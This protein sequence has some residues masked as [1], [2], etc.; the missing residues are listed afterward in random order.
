MNSKQRVALA[1]RGGR[2]DRVP[3]VP[4]FDAG[5]IC[6][7]TRRDPR[8]LSTCGAAERIRAIEEC[9][10]RH[11]QLDGLHVNS[12]CSEH[13]GR[14]LRIEK[15]STH[16]RITNT[17]T[18]EQWGLRPDA[19]ACQPDGTL[20]PPEEPRQPRIS[21]ADDVQRLIPAPPTPEQIEASGR[22]GPLRHLV[23]NYPDR[24]YSYPSHSLM[25]VAID[26]CGGFAAGLTLLATRR[27]LFEKLLRRWAEHECAVVES[28][29]KAGADSMW[30]ISYFA[31]AD[32]ISPRDYADLVFPCE[33]EICR[34]AK[35][36]G[37]FVL[38]WYLGDLMPNLEQVM[39][40]PI[41]ALVLEQGR[42]GYQTDPVKLRP[43]VGPGFCLFGYVF[44]RDLCT[45]NREG[46][47]Q[48]FTRQLAG[49]GLDGAFVAGAPIISSDVSPEALDFYFQQV[50][51]LGEYR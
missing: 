24:H 25:G 48:E 47:S 17:D 18:G 26:A 27:E 7:S 39:K 8:V 10:L 1:L 16:W 46:L 12:G 44:E 41:D 3:I 28:A 34:E 51:R 49:A 35:R 9:F 38:D 5:Y 32:T 21:D 31:G 37:L 22:F 14:N 13:R 6:R 20:R 29:R 30:L 15:L 45:S 42:K 50:R 36:Q 2:P 33:L 11:S 40:L 23:A 4:I 19:T 43:L